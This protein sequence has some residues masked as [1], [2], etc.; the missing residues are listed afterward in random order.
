MKNSRYTDCRII[1]ILK[2]AQAGTPVLEL[3]RENGM[4]SAN[5]Y[6]WRAKVVKPSIL[7][8][9]KKSAAQSSPTVVASACRPLP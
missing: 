6:K 2:Q 7:R 4:S 3:C 9:C 1:A 8:E 5:F